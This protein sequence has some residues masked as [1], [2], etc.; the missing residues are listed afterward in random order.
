MLRVRGKGGGEMRAAF[1]GNL[2]ILEV[3]E[4]R[5]RQGLWVRWDIF[6]FEKE[7]LREN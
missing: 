1:G 2:D 3:G 4:V 6:G 5:R 7:K